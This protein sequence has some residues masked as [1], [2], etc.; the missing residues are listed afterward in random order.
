MAER[1]EGGVNEQ[2]RK[3]YP[4]LYELTHFTGRDAHADRGG[5]LF[6]FIE[7]TRRQRIIFLIGLGPSI[8]VT[9]A[10][11]PLFGAG[12]IAGFF[13]TM[14]VTF[15]LIEFRSRKG[16][17]LR[18]Y[19]TVY[20][21][22]TSID[23]MLILCGRPIAAEN[24]KPGWVR[25]SNTLTHHEAPE[26]DEGLSDYIPGI[27]APSVPEQAVERFPVRGRSTEAR[28]SPSPLNIDDLLAD[29]AESTLV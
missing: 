19:Q 7:Y 9:G 17:R 5:V 4:P 22:Q 11:A 1:E 2:R 16:M 27:D 18:L 25:L 26:D 24:F 10:L 21:R 14:A 20:D 13:V 28:H 29:D 15:V 12:A 8:A 6:G 3:K 23:G